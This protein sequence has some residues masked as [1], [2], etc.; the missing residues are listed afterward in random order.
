M[1]ADVVVA[2]PT[3]PQIAR[4]HSLR[5]AHSQPLRTDTAPPRGHLY[6]IFAATSLLPS[7]T[8]SL[9]GL[10]RATVLFI[11]TQCSLDGLC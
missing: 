7:D 9:K 5:G 6:H 3:P 4:R 2:A 1:A 8:G 10:Q 11:I